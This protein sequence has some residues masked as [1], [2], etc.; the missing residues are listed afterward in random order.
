MVMASFEK[1]KIENA[2]KKL[3]ST[4]SAPCLIHHQMWIQKSVYLNNNFCSFR[5]IYVH[6]KPTEQN[7]LNSRKF[8]TMQ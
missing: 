3:W 1:L 5:Q 4:I 8:S 2:P 6:L 7:T